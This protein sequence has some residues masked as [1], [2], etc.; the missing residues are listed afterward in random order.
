MDFNSVQWAPN[1]TY[2]STNSLDIDKSDDA[3]EKKEK[4]LKRA[5]EFEKLLKEGYAA[6][7]ETDSLHQSGVT[8][9]IKERD[10]TFVELKAKKGDNDIETVVTGHIQNGKMKDM[11]IYKLRNR[12]YYMGHEK[13]SY[14]EN[15]KLKLYVAQT[16]DGYD[17]KSPVDMR[18]MNEEIIEF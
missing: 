2:S 17:E 6:Y 8:T 3:K 14:D 16:H 7:Q 15:G 1:V 5:E 12:V 4:Q 13:Y 9:I 11:R 10:K 18:V